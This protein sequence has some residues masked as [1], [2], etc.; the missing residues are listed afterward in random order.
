MKPCA[1]CGWRDAVEVSDDDGLPACATCLREPERPHDRPHAV[2][3]EDRRV[4]L[5][6]I[7][8]SHGAVSSSDVAD[9]LGLQGKRDRLPIVQELYRLAKLGR[10][11]VGRSSRPYRYLVRGEP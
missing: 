6:G 11:A 10:L 3:T 1:H 7:I 2:I 5:I 4:R 8:R 9:A